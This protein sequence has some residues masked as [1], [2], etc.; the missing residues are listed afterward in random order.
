MKLWL[1]LET[2][3]EVPIKNGTYAY[4][5]NC[6]IMLFGYAVE[7]EDPVV[8]DLTAGDELPME[9][10]YY[11][12]A[13]DC[14][15]WAHNSMFDRNVMRFQLPEYAPPIRQWRDTMIQAYTHGLPGSL[16]KLGNILGLP[17]DQQKLK[18]GKK[19]IQLFCKPRPKNSK[20]PRAT[21]LT[22]PEE[23]ERFKEYLVGDIVSMRATG[24]RMPKVNY[25][26]NS[27]ILELWHYDQE[28]NDR[29]FFVDV[30][31][32]DS[33]ITAV[34]IEKK[35]LKNQVQELTDGELESATKRDKVI[36]F[37]LEQYGIP[38]EDLKKATVEAALLDENIPEPAKEILR[39]RLQATS[40]ST[41]KY[42]ALKKATSPNGRCCGTIQFSGAARTGRAAG[43][44]FQPQ[45][46][47]SRGLLEEY[48]I[49]FGIS[50]L[51]EGIAPVIFPGV[52]KLMVSCVRGVLMAPPGHKLVIADLSN[53][54]GRDSAWLAG[55]RWKLKAFEEF[56]DGRG[57]DLYKLAYAR[58]FAVEVD[59]VTKSQRQIGKVQELMLGY[60]GGV[61][62][63]VTGA[64]GYG[65]DLEELANSIWHT[66]PEE[67]VEL[68]VKFLA[69]NT[70]NKRP[71]YGLSDRA[72][73]TCDVL[74][75]LW[76]LAN[77]SISGFWKTL[78]DAARLA[79]GNPGTTYQAGEHL[80]FR[81]DGKWLRILLPS[82][83]FLCY[84]SAQVDDTGAISY[85]GINQYTKK[86]S[87][88]KTHGGKLLENCAQAV[89]CDVLYS[90][91]KPAEEAGYAVVLHVHDEL[92]TEAIND[93]LLTAGELSR[94]MTT[95]SPWSVGMPLAAAGFESQ[96]YRK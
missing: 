59:S 4:A 48:E 90:A 52:M 32:V 65:F 23:W 92:V 6:E 20:I 82:G 67:Q 77:Y 61:G 64:A 30:E 26:D 39:I 31:L 78:E 94:I 87:R 55:E 45:N 16:D 66:L 14:E 70:K 54:E 50:A 75:R 95:S 43:R 15:K 38:I 57:H 36:T 12:G 84:P 42:V 37:I 91:Q 44:T 34:D 71:N 13:S 33:C 53:I 9:L 22:H 89:A 2:F 19:L 47:P 81:K 79:I 25:P 60:A 28:V 7:D 88:I 35:R 86:W 58:S 93:P 18:D 10:L 62:A 24:K 96:R 80:A 1:D 21:R 51:K 8:V 73:I 68:A 63:F 17:P 56:D 74:K 11:L 76:R 85:L 3:S 5:Q 69:W 49:D 40:T 27:Y 29:G 72:F 41:S 46:L 83:R